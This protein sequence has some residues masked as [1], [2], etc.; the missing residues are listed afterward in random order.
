MSEL[1]ELPFGLPGRVYRSPMPL[2]GFD[3]EKDLLA[4]YQQAGV[5]TVV[6]LVSDEEAQRK[7]GCDLRAEYRQ[8]GL[9]VIYLPM[10]DFDVPEIDALRQGISRAL[11][12]ARAGRTLAVHCHAGLGRTGL[13]LACM[14]R[15]AQGFSGR[16]AIDWVRQYVVC[17]LENEKQERMAE[18]YSC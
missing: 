10:P 13:F 3:R 8:L 14:A 18:E 17:A 1:T 15:Q 6:M 12:Q 16:Q 7:T 11:A 5:Q 9:D 2:S 4:L